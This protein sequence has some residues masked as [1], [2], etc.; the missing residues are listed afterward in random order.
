MK[1]AI[2]SF[3][4]LEPRHIERLKELGDVVMFETTKTQ[5]EALE[6]TDGA[7]VVIADS[8]D[9]PLQKSFFERVSGVR[10]ICLNST[11]FNNVDVESARAHGVM[12]ANVP[13]Y[14]TQA[15]A[16]HTI[17]LM[18]AVARQIP[19][20]DREMNIHPFEIDPANSEH[21]RYKGVELKG[22]TLGIFGL[23]QIGESV[24]QMGAALGMRVIGNS[25]TKKDLPNIEWV[26]FD[27]LLSQSDVLSINS[28]FYPV[29]KN[30]FDEAT[31]SIMKT[32]AILVNTARGDFVD[33]G[34]VRDAILSGKIYGFGAD[35][36]TDWSP[37]NP[38]IGLERVVLTPHAAFFTQESTNRMADIIVSNVASYVS[39]KPANV[40]NS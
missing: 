23:G 5:E 3:S 17:A 38:L 7:E 37:T 9:V 10:Y 39:E 16:E 20:G 25:R 22:K 21:E 13:G 30:L 29:G 19:R 35:V 1:I 36:V 4:F 40:V 27:E 14:S 33:E 18:L 15:V 2:L 24:A 26:E 28:A 11:G 32:G 12:I 6:R 34:A 8:Y 31:L